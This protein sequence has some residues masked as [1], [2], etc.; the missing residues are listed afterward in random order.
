M[1]IQLV[2]TLFPEKKI[3]TKPFPRFTYQEVMEKYG[4]DKPDLRQNKEDQ[5]E[6][7][8]GWIVDF[9][10]FET[11]EDGSIQSQHHPFCSIHPEDLDKLDS[12][13]LS[14]RANAYDLF[15]NGYEL[16]SGSIRIHE[17]ALQKKIF[18]ILGISDEEQQDRFG[19][20]L[21]AFT[22]GAPPHGGFAPGIDRIVMLLAGEPN[23]REVIA[24]PKTGDARDPMMHAP[25]ELE[26]KRLRDVHI[27]LDTKKD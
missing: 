5:N 9:P 16:S 26:E 19:H 12:D 21:D 23:I 2:E 25:S 17:Q 6:L 3:T 24:F 14:V 18:S 20:M 1:F 22:Y 27:K 8:F 13:P 4:T 15:L 7:A 10:M 11:L